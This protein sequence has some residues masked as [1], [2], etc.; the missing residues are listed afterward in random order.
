MGI[1]YGRRMTTPEPQDSIQVMLDD[2]KAMLA[3][4]LLM[5]EADD[6]SPAGDADARR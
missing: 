2:C 1:A 6:L 4:L 3:E 5:A